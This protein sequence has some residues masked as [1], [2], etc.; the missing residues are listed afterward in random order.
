MYFLYSGQRKYLRYKATLKMKKK[1]TSFKE[2]YP[3]YIKEHAN[4]YTKLL[5]FIGSN[6]FLFFVIKL[7][8]SNEMRNLFFAFLSAYGLAWIGHF[9]VEKNKPATFE[10][11][12]Y[13]FMGDCAMYFDIIKGKY[14]IY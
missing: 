1:F 13:S 12:I 9:F 8:V 14:K 6:L 4:K 5:H 2:F 11:P 7:L 3:Y 10:Y